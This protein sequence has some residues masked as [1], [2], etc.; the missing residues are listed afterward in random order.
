MSL[1]LNTVE[2]PPPHAL[3]SGEQPLANF[4]VFYLRIIRYLRFDINGRSRHS[5]STLY[6]VEGCS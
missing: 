3:V 1:V 6:D 4:P 2:Q 5:R